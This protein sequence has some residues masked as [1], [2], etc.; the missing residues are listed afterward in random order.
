[1][2]Y[3]S[4]SKRP[5]L[6]RRLLI[7]FLLELTAV[8][9]IVLLVQVQPGLSYLAL[10]L[11]DAAWLGLVSGLGTRFLL[12]ERH[13]TLSS[14]AAV[15]ALL[16]GLFILGLASGWHYGIGPQEF[17]AFDLAG[18]AQLATGL[19]A[20][21]LAATA[22]RRPAARN[23][24]PAKIATS[25][26]EQAGKPDVVEAN[27][28]A[29]KARRPVAQPKPKKTAG[30]QSSGRTR[31]TPDPAAPITTQAQKS[32]V[33]SPAKSRLR[34]RLRRPAVQFASTEEHRC[35]YCLEIVQPNDPRGIVECKICH[36]LHHADCWAIT[37]TCQV[38]H[39]NA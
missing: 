29:A 8:F 30:S 28:P 17:K 27:Q 9:G 22:W 15:V 3:P 4:P 39:L 18:A 14:L 23:Q 7:L 6:W 10:I 16:S 19:L 24:A 36:A 33:I 20:C 5:P 38:P 37:G 2:T 35:P 1:M 25:P 32:S 12:K 21:L 34:R 31:K 11:L 26:P 13:W